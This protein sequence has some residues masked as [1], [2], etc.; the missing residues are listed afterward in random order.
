M[1]SFI[2]VEWDVLGKQTAQKPGDLAK[3]LDEA[4]IK[5]GMP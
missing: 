4:S 5:P 2:K 3:V 1:T